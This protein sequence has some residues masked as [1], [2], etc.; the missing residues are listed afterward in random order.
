MS[1]DYVSSGSI[2]TTCLLQKARNMPHCCV[3]QCRNRS[4]TNPHLSFYRFPANPATR[5][6]WIL[7]IQRDDFDPTPNTRV[8]SWHFPHGKERGPSRFHW[9]E[10]LKEGQDT[11]QDEASDVRKTRQSRK[12]GG[13]TKH[14]AKSDNPLEI[15]ASAASVMEALAPHP[16]AKATKD[17][18]NR[19]FRVIDDIE[20]YNLHAYAKKPRSA[21]HVHDSKS[22]TTVDSGV[23]EDYVAM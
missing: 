13:S 20:R 14:Y 23:S 18:G 1:R 5:R 7:M 11:P 17:H 2:L 8:C 6:K 10:N 12:M 21:D 3:P 22:E 15:L 16:V 19:Y 4:E 9:T